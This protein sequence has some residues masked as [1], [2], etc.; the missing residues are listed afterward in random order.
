MFFFALGCGGS[1]G[2]EQDEVRNTARD[3][4]EVPH[5]ASEQALYAGAP[6]RAEAV[7]IFG[8]ASCMGVLIGQRTVL[9][10]GTCIIDVAETDAQEIV[11]GD[12]THRGY[13]LVGGAIHPDFE[14][15]PDTGATTNDVAL[16]FLDSAP[17]FRPYAIAKTDATAP[18]ALQWVTI[19]GTGGTGPSADRS[20]GWFQVTSADA[21]GF[22]FRQSAPSTLYF[23]ERAAPVL[24]GD[25]VVG[26]VSEVRY[27]TAKGQRIDPYAAWIG[28]ASHGDVVFAD[29]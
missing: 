29:R 25:T 20:R 15:D 24:A 6:L 9:T 18:R 23:F 27:P 22:S 4:D 8:S 16:V 14:I 3:D 21:F 13:R 19:V 5:V 26:L 11:F 10:T 28:E 7:G 1:L 17:P 12:G 2:L